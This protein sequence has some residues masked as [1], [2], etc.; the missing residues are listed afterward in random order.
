MDLEIESLETKKE[1]YKSIKN[2]MM[3]ELL[4]GKIRL[5]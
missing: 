4:T 1:K 5:V 2:G 3:Q